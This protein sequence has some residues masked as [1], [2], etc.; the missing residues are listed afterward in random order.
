MVNSAT[1]KKSAQIF[2][3]ERV[4][5]G[6]EATEQQFGFFIDLVETMFQY[7]INAQG[8]ETEAKK[9][10][11]SLGNTLPLDGKVNRVLEA[12]QAQPRLER[13]IRKLDPAEEGYQVKHDALQAALG[14]V[15][16]AIGCYQEMNQWYARANS[17]FVQIF[18]NQKALGIEME[19]SRCHDQFGNELLI[20][21]VGQI[22]LVIPANLVQNKIALLFPEITEGTFKTAKQQRSLDLPAASWDTLKGYFAQIEEFT[23]LLRRL[24]DTACDSEITTV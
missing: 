17:V 3:I 11:S 7:K 20:M 23:T 14:Q 6:Y 5:V 10:M 13:L 22:D 8:F 2:Q 12:K 21:R 19:Y 18:I 15:L 9:L 1:V 4:P 24:P 16:K